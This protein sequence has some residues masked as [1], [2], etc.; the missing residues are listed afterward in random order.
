VQP[1]GGNALQLG[2][3][4]SGQ[5]GYDMDTK[6]VVLGAIGAVLVGGWPAGVGG[7]AVGP[8]VALAQ[9]AAP[10]DPQ[11][12]DE[13]PMVREMMVMSIPRDSAAFYADL[14]DLDELQREVAM[15]MHRDYLA[16][17]RETAYA[18]RDAR[19]ALEEK[20]AAG[21][22]DMEAMEE[23]MRGMMRVMLG[24]I[25][26]VMTLG[27]NYVDDLGALASGEQQQ[28][29]HARVVLAREREM[30][31]VMSTMEGGGDGGV[32]DLIAL[33]RQMD[34]PV[35]PEEGAGPAGEALLAYERELGALC[36]P[37]ITRA[38]AAFR[39][40]AEDFSFE[41][42]ANGSNQQLEKEMEAMVQRFTA[43]N[44]RAVRQ[45]HGALPPER[46]GEWMLAYNRAR[47][48]V[49]YGP[50][51]VHRAYDAA[52]ELD[53]LTGEQREML[54]TT[55]AQ[56]TREADAANKKWADAIAD[57]EELRRSMAREWNEE[58]WAR[59]QEL[60]RASKE[61]Q[62]DREALDRRFVD[63]VLGALTDAQR[64]ALPDLGGQGVD[65]DAVLREMGGG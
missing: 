62:A 22:N 18:M 34:P 52:M 44:D 28:A 12:E 41:D 58:L 56:Y 17:Y 47:W 8:T 49:V 57:A 14:M 23:T 24:F 1:I 48:P 5:K 36:G 16:A 35:L 37:F 19:V 39:K 3:G 32:I 59:F 25:D 9:E 50:N 43:I 54:A 42:E 21:G 29:G 13:D 7:R 15:E 63:R 6:R 20:M 10:A 51:D 31:V 30:A 33:G 55:L 45:V 61:V 53:D 26:R 2:A 27:Q 38:F 64:E 4:L 60:D 40:M 46:Q 65:V 11:G